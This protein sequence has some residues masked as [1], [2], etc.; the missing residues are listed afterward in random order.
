MNYFEEV[1]AHYDNLYDSFLKNK[2]FIEECCKNSFGKYY[3]IEAIGGTSFYFYMR[4]YKNDTIDYYEKAIEWLEKATANQ[5]AFIEELAKQSNLKR[6]R[7][8]L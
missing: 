2:S 5:E 3:K 6:K 4:V 8:T 1:R 7:N